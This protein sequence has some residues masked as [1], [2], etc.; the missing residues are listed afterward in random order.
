MEPTKRTFRHRRSSS[1]KI[2]CQESSET[3]QINDG[4]PYSGTMA[5]SLPQAHALVRILP[6]SNFAGRIMLSR[7]W[8]N[9]FCSLVCRSF[10]AVRNIQI[11]RCIYHA[12]SRFNWFRPYQLLCM[13]SARS[14]AF[15]HIQMKASWP[16]QLR[17]FVKLSTYHLITMFIFREFQ[18]LDILYIILHGFTYRF[19]QVGIF[20]NKFR[21]ERLE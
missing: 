6:I 11:C 7:I 9:F 14:E 20:P 4:V 1:Y 19:S 10:P 13:T 15:T 2:H 16:Y 12:V 17:Q 8:D 21:S 5:F 3:L 18:F